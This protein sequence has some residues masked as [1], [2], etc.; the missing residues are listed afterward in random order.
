MFTFVSKP[1]SFHRLLHSKINNISLFSPGVSSFEDIVLHVELT[2]NWRERDL[3]SSLFTQQSA[4]MISVR[5]H[6]L[7]TLWMVRPTLHI[8]VEHTHTA[9]IVCIC[10][11][12]FVCW[13]K[14]QIK[15]LICVCVSFLKGTWVQLGR[16]PENRCALV[17]AWLSHYSMSSKP[18]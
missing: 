15:S 9:V 13:A 1:F 7:H 6:T 10:I 2:F 18:V 4:I 14:P 16:R 11:C 8:Q 12:S 17:R 5:P 3:V